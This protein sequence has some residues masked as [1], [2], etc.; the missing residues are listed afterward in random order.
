MWGSHGAHRAICYTPT[1]VIER[2]SSSK[3][4]KQSSGAAGQKKEQLHLNK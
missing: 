3:H 2:L 4:T 1:H